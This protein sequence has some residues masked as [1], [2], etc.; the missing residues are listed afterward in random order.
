MSRSERKLDH[1][2]HALS[3]KRDAHNHFDDIDLI[4]Q[5]L[6]D[7]DWEH[8]DL[9]TKVGELKLSSPL[10]I[11]AMTGG[12]GKKT[13]EINQSL[14][15]VSAQTGISMAVGS[16][17]AAIKDKIERPSFEIVRKENP[18]GVILANVGSE[19]TVE[20][21]LD[22]V[23][24]VG[25]NALQIHVNTLQELIMPEGDRDFTSRSKNIENIV[26][27]LPIPVIIKEVGY[28][29]SK[30]TVEHLSSLGVTY[31]D[32]GGRGGTNFSRVENLRRE[33]PL[34]AFENWGIPTPISLIEAE[35]TSK[36]LHVIASGGVRNGLDGAK[37]L[38]LGAQAFGMAGSL[39]RTLV[40]QGEEAVVS[41]IHFIT[42]E[43]KMA[44]MLLGTSKLSDLR[45]KSYVTTGKTNDWVE[46]RSLRT[47]C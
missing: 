30:E 23:D 31:I 18:H 16:Q 33:K 4:H 34:T 36:E 43:L 46:Q 27:S 20:Q 10:F 14:A 44:M 21:A 13:I 29:M 24:M 6:T 12:G 35:N 22:A 2:R 9:S 8:L 39:L 37:A 15:R 3:H 32:V 19:S 40:E 5:S 47:K 45:G 1:I 25:A 26:R 28:G 38:V 7:L 41:N 11:N 42:R 17:M